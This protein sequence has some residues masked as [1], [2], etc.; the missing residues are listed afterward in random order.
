MIVKIIKIKFDYYETL[1]I[2]SG[3]VQKEVR[4]IMKRILFSLLIIGLIFAVEISSA[5]SGTV[6]LPVLIDNKWGFIDETGKMVIEPKLD[7]A[8]GFHEDLAPVRVGGEGWDDVGKWGYIDTTGAIVIQPQFDWISFFSEGFAAVRMG[9]EKMGGKG[10]WGFIDKTG[11]MV[12]EPQFENAYGFT[13]GLAEA[14]I[15]PEGLPGKGLWGYIDKTGNIVIAPQFIKANEFSEGLASVCVRSEGPIPEDKWGFIDKTGKFIVE[16]QYDE[17]GNFSEGMAIIRVGDK[18]TGKRGFID[19]TGKV[20][21]EPQYSS[22]SEFKEGLA[23]V[24][25]GGNGTYE[26]DGLWGYIDPAGNMFIAPQF[27]RAEYFSEGLAAA[28]ILKEGSSINNLYGYIDKTGN[29]VIPPQF[30]VADY[31]TDGIA[32]VNKEY[33]T[34]TTDYIDKAGNYIYGSGASI[35]ETESLNEMM[36]NLFSGT[37]PTPPASAETPP[38]IPPETPPV[39]VEE[40]APESGSSGE[41]SEEPSPAAEEAVKFLIM[42]VLSTQSGEIIAVPFTDDEVGI[43]QGK[44]EQY[45]DMNGTSSVPFP[46]PAEKPTALWWDYSEIAFP[47]HDIVTDNEGYIWFAAEKKLG[48]LQHVFRLKPD[49]EVDWSVPVT[50]PRSA[51]LSALAGDWPINYSYPVIVCNDAVIFYTCV[52]DLKIRDY[53]Y[54]YEAYD[55]TGK[56]RWRTEWIEGSVSDR[57]VWRI[58]GNRMLVYNMLKGPNDE[59]IFYSLKDGSIVDRFEIHN[60]AFT[61]M[62]G[63]GPHEMSD[64]TWISFI[65]NYD[66]TRVARYSLPDQKSIWELPPDPENKFTN[67]PLLFPANDRVVIGA[68]NSL[69]CVNTETGEKVWENYDAYKYYPLGVTPQGNIIAIGFIDHK[70]FLMAVDGNGS[71]LWKIKPGDED[72]ET[73]KITNSFS[74]LFSDLVIYNDGSILLPKEESLALLNPDGSTSWELSAEDMGWVY[75]DE[76]SMDL[77]KL[78]PTT[79][80]RIIGSFSPAMSSGFWGYIL[81]L[82][83]ASEVEN[84]VNNQGGQ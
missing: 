60:P 53:K 37:P 17:A 9:G 19:K 40:N 65:K 25:V 41:V 82:G 43:P 74:F 32:S 44:Y 20:V 38:A 42:N 73:G 71:L 35:A 61:T 66:Q 49:G 1:T 2:I 27:C 26:G 48:E 34:A 33:V 8:F 70:I 30:E 56:L 63:G 62:F 13:D 50:L 23:P 69:I 7:W 80:G 51:L 54:A 84:E 79:D 58:S 67:W 29:F 21:I 57:N 10:K 16:P 75:A 55:K 28:S 64:G 12:I 24:R 39:Q 81:C 52:H 11:K 83:P 77:W 46:P 45:S 36:K 15:N 4:K 18:N 68:A 22:A 14:L 6:R 31:F 3:Q 78:Y 72:P 59:L 47:Y 76:H 5:A